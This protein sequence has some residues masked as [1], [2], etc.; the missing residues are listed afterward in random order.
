MSAARKCDV[1]E[2]Y[3]DGEG[4]WFVSN[5]TGDI[6]GDMFRGG[7]KVVRYDVCSLECLASLALDL[8]AEVTA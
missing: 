5:A 3:G 6:F 7:G 8:G 1:C 2:Q 4:W